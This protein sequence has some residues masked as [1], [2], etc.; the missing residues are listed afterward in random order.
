MAGFSFTKIENGLV[1]VR[2]TQDDEVIK[3]ILLVGFFI[4]NFGFSAQSFAQNRPLKKVV[5]GQ[6]AFVGGDV[7]S[8]VGQGSEN[9]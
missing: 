4:Y 6:T 5:W 3:R 1:K 8:V 9:L 7:D 2:K